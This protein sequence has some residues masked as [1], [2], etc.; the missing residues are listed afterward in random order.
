MKAIHL[1]FVF[2]LA[3]AGI[4]VFVLISEPPTGATGVAHDTIA[5]MKLGG[6][7]AAR[8]ATIGRTPFYFQLGV[9]GFAATLLYMG[10]A[11]RRRDGALRVAILTM[12]AV[13][14][15]IWYML[16]SGYEDYLATGETD[17]VFGF[18]V[19][20]NWM[21]W[22]IWGSFAIFDLFY[23]VAFRRYFLPKED[24]AEFAALVA[25]LKADEGQH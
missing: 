7:G 4:T 16:Y 6:D 15:F 9:I 10:V 5:G 13:A 11:E 2:L 12:T 22:G 20:T 3:I 18:P 25:E 17:V 23:V 21:F 19:P 24:E 1:A 14:L 8:L